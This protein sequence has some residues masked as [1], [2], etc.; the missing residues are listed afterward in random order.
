MQGGFIW[1]H[2]RVETIARTSLR[3]DS[4][5]I[6]IDLDCA[7]L[8]NPGSIG[9]PRD[10]DPRAAY[11]LYDSDASMLTYYRVEY[12]VAGAQKAIRNAGLPDILADRLSVGR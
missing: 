10:G 6:E 12:D 5:V 11:V 8:V 9:Q 3:C 4:Q 1:N 7:Y 2:S